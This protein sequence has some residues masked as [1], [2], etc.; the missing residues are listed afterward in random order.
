MSSSSGSANCLP[1]PS[2]SGRGS[3]PSPP[4]AATSSMRAANFSRATRR[5]TPST[6]APTPCRMRKRRQGRSPPSCRSPTS[7]S[8]PSFPTVR[9]RRSSSCA[10]WK[11]RRSPPW[12]G[13]TCKASITRGITAASI[14]TA[15]LAARCSAFPLRTARDSRESKSSTTAILR[16]RRGRSCTRPTSSA[17]RSRARA[18]PTSPQRTGST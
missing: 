14:L 3:F 12:R 10:A 5:R 18:L 16:A 15:L 1:A 11:R 2:I 4:S 6:P 7:P 8:L 13:Q 9:V 17:P